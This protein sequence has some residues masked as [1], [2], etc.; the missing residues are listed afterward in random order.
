M[1]TSDIEKTISDALEKYRS[2]AKKEAELTSFIDRAIGDDVVVSSSTNRTL[3][4]IGVEFEDGDSMHKILTGILSST[5][6]DLVKLENKI[7]KAA[8]LIESELDE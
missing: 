6:K 1:I 4:K 8:D 3:L 2:L 5:Q 7:L